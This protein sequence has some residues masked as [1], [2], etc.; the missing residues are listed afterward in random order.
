MKNLEI[1]LHTEWDLVNISLRGRREDICGN[2]KPV[3]G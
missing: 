3:A 2:C 1:S